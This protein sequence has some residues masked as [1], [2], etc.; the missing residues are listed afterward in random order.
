ML[1]REQ[2]KRNNSQQPENQMIAIVK[3]SRYV[4]VLTVTIAHH[5]RTHSVMSA[6]ARAFTH[7]ML[8]SIWY[9][10][11]FAYKLLLNGIHAFRRK[12]NCFSVGERECFYSARIM[13]H[14]LSL[15]FDILLSSNPFLLFIR[16]RAAHYAIDC[17][18]SYQRLMDVFWSCRQAVALWSIQHN[19]VPTR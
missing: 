9:Q 5:S 15:C 17:T 4:C 1:F 7:K 11:W 8:S 12:S 13:K 6:R 19:S 16:I 18:W 2:E 3:F 14:S 10:R